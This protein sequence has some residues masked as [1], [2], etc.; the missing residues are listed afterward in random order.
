MGPLQTLQHFLDVGEG[1]TFFLGSRIQ[2]PKVYAKA[3]AT[4]LFLNQDNCIAPGAATESNSP[5]LQHIIHVCPD[6]PPTMV[7]GC[8]KTTP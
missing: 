5:R 8:V 4:I 3:E 6:F 7:V 2:L 1:V